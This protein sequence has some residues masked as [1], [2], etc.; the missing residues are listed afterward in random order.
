[1]KATFTFSVVT[2]LNFIFNLILCFLV[3]VLSLS[4]VQLFCNPEDC[5]PP[6]SSVHGIFQARIPEWVTI[7]FSRW[8]SQTR[9]WLQ[10]VC[11]GRWVFLPL[12]HQG[13]PVLFLTLKK[14]AVSL[15]L[16][17][18]WIYSF[19]HFLYLSWSLMVLFVFVCGYLINL[20]L[21]AYQ[22]LKLITILILLNKR[23]TLNSSHSFLLS[24]YMILC[25][26][27]TYIIP[28]NII[29]I[30]AIVIFFVI[31][32][33]QCLPICWLLYYS[34]PLLSQ[35]FHVGSLFWLRVSWWQIGFCFSECLFILY[36]FLKAF[37]RCRSLCSY[38][39]IFL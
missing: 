34:L 36:T 1:M 20:N 35:S 10:I 38:Q 3:V 25:I 12:S 28:Q 32:Y 21:H 6:G 5:S 24:I 8:S 22:S 17:L 14:I 26:L 37:A 27:I 4:H 9:D 16:A 29:D 30:V 19:F 15:L 13:S 23:G 18:F 7:S 39:V 11:I 33:S 31:L 2:Y